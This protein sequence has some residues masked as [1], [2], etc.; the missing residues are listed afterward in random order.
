M[1]AKNLGLRPVS[2]LRQPCRALLEVSRSGTM[3]FLGSAALGVVMG[4]VTVLDGRG[5][6][7]LSG[8]SWRAIVFGN[9]ALLGTVALAFIYERSRSLLAASIAFAAGMFAAAAVY[10]TRAEQDRKVG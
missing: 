5:T 3:E 1:A 9:A 10:R 8:I 2:S 7:R 4:W 6:I